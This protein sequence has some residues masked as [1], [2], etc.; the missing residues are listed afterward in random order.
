MYHTATNAGI[1]RQNASQQKATSYDMR[2]QPGPCHSAD[3]LSSE[4]LGRSLPSCANIPDTSTSPAPY[5]GKLITRQLLDAQ[6]HIL[7]SRH[8]TQFL[9]LTQY[10]VTPCLLY[11]LVLIAVLLHR[12]LRKNILRETLHYTCQC[13]V[14]HRR[15]WYIT[16]AVN[17][18]CL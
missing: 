6:R 8:T 14:S 16:L 10:L 18:L 13:T 11:A 9:L 17:P 5:V 3:G 15:C 7:M 4:G 2:L 12:P 1:G